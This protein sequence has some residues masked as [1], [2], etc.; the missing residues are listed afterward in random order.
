M[1]TILLN[2]DVTLGAHRS[3][4]VE[5]RFFG[6]N[7]LAARDD[8]DGTYGS[9]AKE[10]GVKL[11]RFPGGGDAEALFDITNP[12]APF[13]DNDGGTH[14]LSDF[15]QFAADHGMQ[16]AIVIP[17][18]V[19]VSNIN[20]GKAVLAQFVQ[21]LTNGVYGPVDGLILE[22]GNEYY[23][24]SRELPP[25]TPEEYA[26]V[27]SAFAPVI[28][29]ASAIDVSI[30]V[31][32]GRTDSDNRVILSYFDTAAER[33]PLDSITLH[34]YPWRFDSIETRGERLKDLADTWKNDGLDLDF[35]LSEWNIGSSG[36][37]SRDADHDY[38]MPQ[39][40]ALLEM[41]ANS[42][43]NGI[44]AAAIWAVQQSNKTS[45][46]ADEGYGRIW[47]AG[48]LF[49]MMAETIPGKKLVAETG[50]SSSSGLEV[51][52]FES[53]EEVVLF[54]TVRDALDEDAGDTAQV[55]IDISGLG[56][57][58]SSAWGEQISTW[59]EEDSYRP[60][61]T[62]SRFD[63]DVSATAAG[64]TLSL[65][66]TSDFDV[67]Q[68]V[69]GKSSTEA[70]DQRQDGSSAD[71]HLVSGAGDDIIFGYTGRDRIEGGDG[72]DLL[73]GGGSSD[74][75]FG[76]DG[77]DLITGD[78]HRD[79]LY[80]E[81][82]ND[83]ITG[84]SKKDRLFGGDGHDELVGD[85]GKDQLFGGDGRD[86]LNG[87]R[88]HDKLSGG[89]DGDVFIFEKSFGDDIVRDFEVHVDMIRLLNVDGAKGARDV[90]NNHATQVG[91]DVLI[92]FS[93]SSI[94]LENTLLDDLS[95]GNF[96]FE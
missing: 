67:F 2:A 23:S 1:A 17:T 55:S 75:I 45:L 64:S 33:D 16:P 25:I 59:V 46:A 94:I 4:V 9:V 35:F 57:S 3:A 34:N 44:D 93:D 41:V 90:M 63:P 89:A 18:K 60:P 76:G 20:A 69:L 48:H 14:R 29:A 92:L 96:M 39:L 10:L 28:E 62:L 8:L 51:Y 65:N 81:A 56:S 68:I 86:Y 78:R 37:K 19:W 36:D 5:D 27:A 88:G 85:R 30:S 31:Q 11:L 71:D 79:K 70:A 32:G 83:K 54:V 91:D 42:T 95:A 26:S 12:D 80:G 6:A 7:F 61:A 58:F 82:G 73:R 13:T 22:I 38:G 50:S 53:A 74:V 66:V 40:A 47:A 87:G 72:H 21:D 24:N 15:L 49:R 43:E 77:H 84:G 52:A